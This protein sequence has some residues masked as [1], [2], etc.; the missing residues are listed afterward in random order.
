MV[1]I[2]E[3]ST[4]EDKVNEFWKKA[5]IFKKSVDKKAPNGDYV[6]YDGPPFATGTPHY[7]HIVASIIKDVVPRFWTMNG[8]RV[9][10]KWGWDC[11]GLPIENIV[12]K[13][14]GSKTKKDIEKIGI[15]KFNNLCQSKV[16]GYVN[17]WKN[18]IKKLGRWADMDNPYRTMDLK[19]M[20]SIWW[21]FKEIYDKGLVYEGY[22]SMHICPRCETTLSQSEV[23]EG[24]KDVKDL[25]VVAEFRLADEENTSILAWTTTPWTLIGNVALAVGKDIDYVKVGLAPE[26]VPR[27]ISQKEIFTKG[28]NKKYILAK[29]KLEEIFS[30][31]KYKIL[32]EFKGKDLVGKKY[33]PLFDYYANDKNL[34]NRE[35][36]WNIYVGDF[37]TTEEGTGIVHIA[38]AF[39]EDDMKLGEKNNLPFVQHVSMDGIIKK[40]VKDFAGLNVKPINDYVSTDLEIIKYLA[41]KDLV[42]TK[43]KYEHSYPHCWRCDTPL[44]NYATSSWFVNVIKMKKRML[45]F[46]KK[47]NWSPGH[48]KKG[49]WGNWL[50]G[51]RDW[52]ISRQRFWASVIPIW[53]CGCGEIKVIGSVKELEKLSGKKVVDLHKHVVDKIMFNCSKCR[54]KMKRIPDVLDCWFESGA[55]PF[56]QLHYPFENKSKFEKNFPA[57][58]IAEGADQTRAWFYYLHILATGVKDVQAFNN[59]IVNGIVLAED[60]KKMSKKLQN[61]PDPSVLMEKY[62]ADALRYYLLTSSVMLADNLNFSEKGVQEALRK[63]IMTLLNVVNFYEEVITHRPREVGKDD[64]AVEDFEKKSPDNLL[65]KWILSRLGELKS[66]IT[67]NMEK[68]DLPSATR[69]ITGFIEDL[70]TWYLRQTRERLNEEDVGALSTL[71]EVLET[72]SKLIAPFM[73]FTAESIWQKLTGNNFKDKNKSVHL[74]SWPKADEQ[75]DKNLLEEMKKVRE[76]VSL[77]L[78]QRDKNHVGLKWPLNKV[79][80]C[81]EKIK[82]YDK[83]IM[84]Q[85]NVKNIE[86]KS[87]KN[88]RVE[89]DF[90]LTSELEAE[91]YARELSRH[92]QAF[93]KKIGLQK[94]DKIELFIFIDEEFKNILEKQKQFIKERTNSKRLNLESVTTGKEKFKNKTDFKIKDKRGMIVI[95][96]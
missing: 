37:V 53:K 43:K 70:S 31:K 65:D 94:K 29:E 17:D 95:K 36:G 23:S 89:L 20:E 82:N 13:E 12:E 77:G 28:K 9:E 51:A 44:L 73:P 8:F 18:V 74:E 71:H 75:I 24:Y 60:G 47:I 87:G 40:E 41:K 57:Q 21:V 58:F 35:N 34:E 22:C 76:I 3:I 39:G 42:F 61:Y 62:G 59:V 27:N 25:S 46:A 32:K 33:K 49:R 63:N 69:P 66:E 55:M 67:Q 81:S 38:P 1:N 54:K 92:V 68:Y 91:G 6:F 88:L 30:D 19:F 72:L 45:E 26:G 79:T 5:E 52:S 14:L 78:M 84:G 4:Q 2:N 85:L 56:A 50:K 64:L 15:D 10:R 16:L 80:I 83:I 93:R 7:G 48:I 96:N 90:N 11:H 86:F